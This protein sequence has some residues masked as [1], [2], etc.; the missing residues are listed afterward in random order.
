MVKLSQAQ[1]N[2]I[3]ERAFEME[4][5]ALIGSILRVPAVMGGKAIDM[6]RRLTLSK[7][8]NLAQK[9]ADKYDMLDVAASK[10]AWK[11]VSGIRKAV[12]KRIMVPLENWHS[13]VFAKKR[14]EVPVYKTPAYDL[15]KSERLK[16]F[17]S[18]KKLERSGLAP[19]Q[20]AM[21]TS[22][23]VFT[24]IKEKG[25][26]GVER[27][28]DILKGQHVKPGSVNINVKGKKDFLRSAMR[29]PILS[30]PIA[31]T[32]D[33]PF[34]PSVLPIASQISNPVL[35]TAYGVAGHFPGF[36][37][38]LASPA[39]IGIDRGIR[40]ATSKVLGI[41]NRPYSEIDKMVQ[42]RMLEKKL[43][44]KSTSPIT[45]KGEATPRTI[46]GQEYVAH[47]KKTYE[48]I[49]EAKKQLEM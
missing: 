11:A 26:E 2:A 25:E 9:A 10:P 34:V 24:T 42:A 14:G 39:T 20:R 8:L 31:L 45:F 38:A 19:K 43:Q 22:R 6:V 4:K 30:A 28:R 27:I 47:H 16:E 1:Y 48:T 23:D 33:N 17:E 18:I 44:K 5:D 41:R 12:H 32:L 21:E 13:E 36:H 46:S 29:T 37:T 40:K 15:T 49:A 35:S 3:A 7:N